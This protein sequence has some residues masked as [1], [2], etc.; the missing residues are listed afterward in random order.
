MAFCGVL[1]SLPSYLQ[2][3]VVGQVLAESQLTFGAKAGQ[4]FNL[5]KE[6]RHHLGA[7]FE[8]GAVLGC[9]PQTQVTVLVELRALVIEAVSHLVAYD[10]ADGT[11]VEGIVCLH[12]EE[13]RL[14]DSGR[15]ADLVSRG[16]I[17]SVH[18]LR[19]HIPLCVI[20][21]LVQFTAHHVLNL[22]LAGLLDVLPVVASNLQAFVV[23]PL[24]GIAHLHDEGIQFLVSHSFR[25]VAHPLLRVDTLAES[26]LQVTNQLHHALLGGCWEIFLNIET[27]YGLTKSTLGTAD[28]TLPTRA[29]FLLARHHLTV[30]TEAGG[31]HLVVEIRGCLVDELPG[32]IVLQ[33][34]ER[35][36]LPD[37]F[38]LG[39][40]LRLA[41]ADFLCLAHAHNVHIDAPVDAREFGLQLLNAHLVV[42][43]LGVTQ[44][45]GIA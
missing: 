42:V 27:A 28:G 34:L 17:V 44:I 22:P 43:L 39:E 14:Q 8:L 10:N 21:G 12:V 45:C 18:H 26:H 25:G 20:H 32:H 2:T 9:P 7:L 5:V 40:K 6:V 41:Y 16:I 36:V 13:G 3:A 15:E 4:Y 33:I 29:V 23:L 38:H 30:E 31:S 11:V 37:G 1:I 19:W 35:G 24:I